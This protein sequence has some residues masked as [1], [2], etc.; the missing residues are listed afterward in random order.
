MLPFSE[1]LKLMMLAL[2]L[3]VQLTAYLISMMQS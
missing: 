2:K 3:G 1:L